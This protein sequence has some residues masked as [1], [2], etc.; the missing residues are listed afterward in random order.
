MCSASRPWP[1]QLTPGAA[2]ARRLEGRFLTS[3]ATVSKRLPAKLND[4]AVFIETL[5]PHVTLPVDGP[6]RWPIA[7][8]LKRV[9]APD[10]TMPDP[11]KLKP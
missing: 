11:A 5:T 3:G 7:D 9:G 1:C 10:T 6:P 8:V 4:Q 2:S